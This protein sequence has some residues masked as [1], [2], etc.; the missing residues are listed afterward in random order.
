LATIKSSDQTDPEYRQ[1]DDEVFIRQL[2][3]LNGLPIP[4]DE[5][6][7]WFENIGLPKSELIISTKTYTWYV[8]DY[9]T[10]RERALRNMMV[11]TINEGIRQRYFSLRPDDNRWPDANHD[12]FPAEKI[13][14]FS[15]NDIP[16]LAQVV[17]AGYGELKV[18]AIFWPTKSGERWLGASFPEFRGGDAFA[19]GWLE[20]RT[21]AWIQFSRG[22]GGLKCRG[23]RLETIAALDI[24]PLGYADRGTFRM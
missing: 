8:E 23:A 2:H 6:F 22:P 16:V 13:F 21:G 17:N 10:A 18:D 15:I 20:R 5:D 12:S 11:A 24:T 19:Y 3:A 4:P 9:K 7:D 1:L 14:R